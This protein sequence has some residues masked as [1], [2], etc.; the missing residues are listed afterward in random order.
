MVGL[1]LLGWVVAKMSVTVRD[2]GRGEWVQFF[3]LYTSTLVLV[4][5]SQKEFYCLNF[6]ALAETQV[7][8]SDVRSWQ[9][10]GDFLKTYEF[11]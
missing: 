3:Y 10:Y 2:G 11:D 5:V 1:N 7:E 9:S 8:K 4:R 6:S